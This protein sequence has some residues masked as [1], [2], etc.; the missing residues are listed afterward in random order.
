MSGGPVKINRENLGVQITK[1]M[2]EIELP[3]WMYGIV[4][5]KIVEHR[6]DGHAPGILLNGEGLLQNN[7]V[8]ETDWPNENNRIDVAVQTIPTWRKSEVPAEI[9]HKME[10]NIK[11]S[12]LKEP[13]TLSAVLVIY[14][15]IGDEFSKE[16]DV[17]IL[18]RNRTG[19]FCDVGKGSQAGTNSL[20][21]QLLCTEELS[22]VRLV[23]VMFYSLLTYSSLPKWIDSLRNDL[24]LFVRIGALVRGR[25]LA[26][27]PVPSRSSRSRATSCGYNSSHPVWH[28]LYECV[29]DIH[30]DSSPFLLQPFQE[31]NNGFWPRLTSPRPAIQ[32]VP[33]MF[34][35]VEVGSLG[36]PVQSA[37]IVVG[38]LRLE[39]A[40]SSRLTFL[41][42]QTFYMAYLN[43]L[44]FAVV[45]LRQLPNKAEAS[46]VTYLTLANSVPVERIMLSE[47]TIH[48][49]DFRTARLPPRI[50]GFCSRRGHSR[51][52]VSANS[53]GRCRWSAGFLGDLPFVPPLHFGAASY[54]PRFTL[55]GSQDL[56]EGVG[57]RT[58]SILVTGFQVKLKEFGFLSAGRRVDDKAGLECSHAST[59]I[60]PYCTLRA[61]HEPV[62]RNKGVSSCESADYPAEPGGRGRGRVVSSARSGADVAAI[63]TQLRAERAPRQR[64]SRRRR[65]SWPRDRW[66][67]PFALHTGAMA[68]RIARPP[69]LSDQQ[70]VDRTPLALQGH[71]EHACTTFLSSLLLYTPQSPVGTN[72]TYRPCI[73]PL[74]IVYSR[75]LRT[76][77]EPKRVKRGSCGASSVGMQRRGKW[78]IPRE[79]TSASGI[80]RRNKR[81]L[82]RA[83][84]DLQEE[85]IRHKLYDEL[86]RKDGLVKED[87]LVGTSH[88]GRRGVWCSESQF[89]ERRATGCGFWRGSDSAPTSAVPARRGRPARLPPRR[90]G[91]NPRPGRSGFSHVGTV[92]DDAVDRRV[93]SGI[94]R[95]PPPLHSG[96]APYSPP[97]PSSA[98]K[99]SL[100]R[101]TPLLG[102][103]AVARIDEGALRC[104]CQHQCE[105]GAP[106]LTLRDLFPPPSSGGAVW[107]DYFRTARTSTVPPRQRTRFSGQHIA[108]LPENKHPPFLIALL[109]EMWVRLPLQ[110]Q[111]VPRKQA[112]GR[113][114][115]VS[116]LLNKPCTAYRAEAPIWG[117]GGSGF[118]SRFWELGVAPLK[119]GINARVTSCS[120]AVKRGVLAPLADC[121]ALILHP[122][123]LPALKYNNEHVGNGGIKLSLRFPRSLER[124]GGCREAQRGME[125][126]TRSRATRSHLSSVHVPPVRNVLRVLRAPSPTVGFTHRFHTLSF[127]HTKNTRFRDRCLALNFAR[128][129]PDDLHQRLPVAGSR[130]IFP[131]SRAA[132]RRAVAPASLTRIF[133]RRRYIC[134]NLQQGRGGL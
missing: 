108:T 78:E 80:A 45:C 11:L 9:Y 5:R 106:A 88:Q 68:T 61:A 125:K 67:G 58:Q 92:P 101:A 57:I 54:S 26:T 93:Y 98:L 8:I 104:L 7:L 32:F 53:A 10:I 14:S 87:L 47:E 73:F 35:R 124:G 122:F 126:T 13:A 72:A 85:V 117:E 132:L 6:M 77:L 131:N 60:R 81:E 112:T 76:S 40:L 34:Y 17:G 74:P 100:L 83:H 1:M 18:T 20:V 23:R 115:L 2:V 12:R 37:N 107:P 121:R 120:E 24:L 21:L 28:A 116:K 84:L 111:V 44:L 41:H 22:L 99:T 133:L 86:G 33:K 89:C 103:G 110:P 71:N 63:S 102:E 69:S 27:K 90:S 91:L 38:I 105:L 43:T 48:S 46:S 96:A 51:I 56:G 95:S 59:K 70:L 109:C 3:K 49:K 50:A 36:G 16:W 65:Y 114:R 123:P 128:T 15:W 119:C 39:F 94:S 29:Q 129:L 62:L 52:F 79:N 66:W 42:T 31:L 97:S 19:K 82:A 118:E 55:I 64:R 30:R 4:F 113:S 127:I 130:Q 75:F 134:R 25:I